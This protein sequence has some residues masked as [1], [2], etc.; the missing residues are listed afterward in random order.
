MMPCDQMD[1][2]KNM[3]ARNGGSL[4]SLLINFPF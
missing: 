4:K 2:G 1:D 3:A